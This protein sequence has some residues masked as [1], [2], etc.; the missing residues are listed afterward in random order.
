M[1]MA[2]RAERWRV[3]THLDTPDGV[4]PLT[5]RQLALLAG[6]GLYVGPALAWAL[7]PFG[8]SL[9]LSVPLVS[10]NLSAGQA[11][12]ML[13]A[14]AVAT[15]VRVL[16][17]AATRARPD[18]GGTALPAAAAAG[19]HPGGAA[20]WGQHRGWPDRA[21]ARPTTVA[22]RVGAPIGQHTPG[23]HHDAGAPAR[24]L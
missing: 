3:P 23:R 5:A 4:G 15:P 10:D 9:G 7:G 16:G 6:A 19:R 24:T 20:G 22:R 18:R 1:A 21:R 13:G 17:R 12:V 8:P 14:L 11:G 2:E